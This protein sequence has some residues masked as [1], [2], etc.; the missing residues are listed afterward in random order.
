MSSESKGLAVIEQDN[1]HF[2]VQELLEGT[3]SYEFSYRIEAFRAGH[4][5]FKVIRDR[6]RMTY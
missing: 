2:V 6:R 5:D 4:E 3:G 1:T